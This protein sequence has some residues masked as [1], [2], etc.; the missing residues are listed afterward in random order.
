MSENLKVT[1]LSSP[2]LAKIEDQR[3]QLY[4]QMSSFGDLRAGTISVHFSKCGKKNCACYQKGHP[5]HGPRYLWSATRQGKT[6]AQ[7]L[8][9]GTELDE[10]R[11]QVDEG[12]RF[13]S[14]CQEIIELNEKICRLRPVPEIE[15]EKE[16]TVL[17]KKLQRSFL[18]KRKKKSSV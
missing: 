10:A 4:Q 14:C 12:R 17:K 3:R 15:D 11:K 7:H 1:E 13:Q 9:L 16:L 2:T 18:R 5:G 8:R 6:V